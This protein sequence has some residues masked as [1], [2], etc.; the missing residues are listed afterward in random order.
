[1]RDAPGASFPLLRTS[2]AAFA[3]IAISIALA[4]PPALA[5]VLAY[6]EGCSE[7]FAYLENPPSEHMSEFMLLSSGHEADPSTTWPTDTSSPIKH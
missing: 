1:M 4:A 2:Q 3:A 6:G 7:C 5:Q